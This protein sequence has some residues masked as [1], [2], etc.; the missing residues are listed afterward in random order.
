M[1]AMKQEAYRALLAYALACTEEMACGILGGKREGGRR[2]VYRVC[3]LPNAAHSRERFSFDRTEHSRA[4]SD[5][6]GERL[7]ASRYS[8]C[9]ESVL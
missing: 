6:T 4:V 8:I 9:R 7:C 5:L 1:L 3:P 2:V